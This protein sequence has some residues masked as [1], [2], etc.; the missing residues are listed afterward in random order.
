MGGR[1]PRVEIRIH[2]RATADR[3]RKTKERSL[4]DG[5]RGRQ[6]RAGSRRRQRQEPRLV[7]RAGTQGAGRGDRAHLPGRG[8]RETRP[9]ARRVRS[10]RWWSG[11]LDVTND[12]QIATHDVGAA[13]AV[14]RARHAGPCGRVR[15]PRRSARS[16]S[17]REPRQLRAARWRSAPTRWWRWR[18]RPSR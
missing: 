8:A 2:A 17:D 10:A 6:A 1:R 16:L 11:E 12:V 7:D 14:G 3:K 13:R 9:T 4:P 5:Y 18:A 15:R